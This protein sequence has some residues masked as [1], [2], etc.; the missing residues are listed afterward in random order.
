M[1]DLSKETMTP[2][3]LL[4]LLMDSDW[5]RDG[6]LKVF[7]GVEYEYLLR[8]CEVNRN[9]LINRIEKEEISYP[10][11]VLIYRI[12][13]LLIDKWTQEKDFRFLNLLYKFRTRG[14]FNNFPKNED[15]YKLNTQ[16]Q[17]ELNRVLSYD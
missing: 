13:R 8:F 2:T 14:Y 11:S 4:C 10:T 12:C 3:R 1:T 6:R 9:N 17:L 7:S 16:I 15:G 5:G